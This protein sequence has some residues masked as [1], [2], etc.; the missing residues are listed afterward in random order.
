MTDAVAVETAPRADDAAALREPSKRPAHSKRVRIPPPPDAIGL[1]TVAPPGSGK[2]TLGRVLHALY[3]I[4]HVMNDVGRFLSD[5]TAAARTHRVV[6]ADKVHTDAAMRRKTIDALRSGNPDMRI[7]ILYW[8]PEPWAF[9]S[10]PEGSKP[11]ADDPFTQM[12]VKRV[13]KRGDNHHTLLGTNP[14]HLGVIK[15][16][17]A[18]LRNDPPTMNEPVQEIISLN[19]SA[20]VVETLQTICDKLSLPPVSSDAVQKNLDAISQIRITPRISPRDLK[21]HVVYYGLFFEEAAMKH[22][23]KLAGDRIGTALW[24]PLFK[25]F[26]R[27]IRWAELHVTTV[28][29]KNKPLMRETAAW[30]EKHPESRFGIA[31]TEIVATPHYFIA[32]VKLVD[33]DGATHLATEAIMANAH[34]HITLATAGPSYKPVLSN[35]ILDPNDPLSN[36]AVHHAVTPPVFLLGTLRAHVQQP[37]G[38]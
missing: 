15:I 18:A 26:C 3:Q 5:L 29:F 37:L 38:A 33:D 13:Q 9:S 10:S 6:Y 19:P 30:L 8:Q 7:V 17:V 14:M 23:L 28:F 21:P 20:S 12:L 34:P 35:N 11:S 25:Q 1:V 24:N 27:R 32:A 4:P 36:D 31:I 16:H 22:A 2:S